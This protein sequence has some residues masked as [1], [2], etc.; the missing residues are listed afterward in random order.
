M[1][2]RIMVAPVILIRA[3]EYLGFV[4][5]LQICNFLNDLKLLIDVQ[6]NLRIN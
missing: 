6:Q 4:F 1:K 5:Q 3:G 2:S